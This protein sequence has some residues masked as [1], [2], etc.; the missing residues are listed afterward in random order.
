MEMI[1]AFLE[2]DSKK[3]YDL[4][5]PLAEEGDQFA[6][7]NLGNYYLRGEG[8]E[9]DYKQAFKWYSLSAKQGHKRAQFDLGVM[10]DNGE[11]IPKNHKEAFKW[12]RLA[13]EQGHAQAKVILDS[14]RVRPQSGLD[15]REQEQLDQIH[16]HNEFREG[17]KQQ[18]QSEFDAEL[19]NRGIT[20]QDIERENTYI[21]QSREAR[22]FGD[23]AGLE[24]ADERKEAKLKETEIKETRNREL[25]EGKEKAGLDGIHDEVVAQYELG[26]AYSQG[27]GVQQNYK[28]AVKWYRL[29]A[30]QENSNAQY[31]L[32][33]MYYNGYGVL[34]DH[35]LSHMWLNISGSNGHSRAIELRNKLEKKMTPSQIEKAQEMARNWKPTKKWTSNEKRLQVQTFQSERVMVSRLR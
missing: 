35:V 24:T 4:N 9:Q 20:V 14:R 22:R 23:Y 8:V 32:G 27:R 13:A 31:S 25:L 18:A 12:F 5:L 15:L 26:L 16:A 21:R 30:E 11:G 3:L 19:E 2:K 1:N 7:W 29:S 34:Q 17:L 33:S 6:Q 10:Y 28:E